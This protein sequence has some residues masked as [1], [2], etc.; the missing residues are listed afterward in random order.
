[1]EKNELLSY[2]RIADFEGDGCSVNEKE[3]IQKLL[4]SIAMK[5]G[6]TKNLQVPIT[7]SQ[8]GTK[9]KK[10][11]STGGMKYRTEIIPDVELAA[12]RLIRDFLNNRLR[13]YSRPPI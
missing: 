13:Y 5:K 9:K 3:K 6:F 10:L 12:R 11:H 4:C 8:P 1:M 2:Y 7:D